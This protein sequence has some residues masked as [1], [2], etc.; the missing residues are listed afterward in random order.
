LA[1]SFASLKTDLSAG[2]RPNEQ[3]LEAAEYARMAPAQLV[4]ALNHLDC[5]KPVKQGFKHYFHFETR[6]AGSQAKV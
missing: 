4:G 1:H 2:T 6:Q 3:L 5:G